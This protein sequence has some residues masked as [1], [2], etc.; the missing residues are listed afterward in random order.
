MGQLLA[1][2]YGKKRC[3][4]AYTDDLQLIASGLTTVETSTLLDFLKKYT[5]E[6]SVEGLVVGLPTDLRGEVSE[7]ES[8][9]RTFISVF[10]KEFPGIPVYRLDERFTSKMASM[11]I[12]QSGKSR[13]ERQKKELIDKVS[14]TLI[15]QNYLEQR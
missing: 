9:I 5:A 1:V 2:D 6:N 3:G 11:Y 4:I 10:E 8:D 7:I 14:A 12:S 13:K 15:L